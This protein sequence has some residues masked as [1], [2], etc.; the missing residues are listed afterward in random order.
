VTSVAWAADSRTLFYVEEHPTTK[1]SYRLHRRVIDEP[2]DALI[3]EEAD[4]LYDIGVGDTRS[5]RFVLLGAMSKDT[6]EMRVLPATSRSGEFRVVEP[7]R[8]GT[9][10]TSTITR[11]SSSSAPTTRAELPPGTRAGCR[12]VGEELAAGARA[13]ARW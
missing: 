6:S 11:T 7:R 3:Y 9:S 1:R 5:E 4:E 8:A 2:S 13:S 12:P 10:T